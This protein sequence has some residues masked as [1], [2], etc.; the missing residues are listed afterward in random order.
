MGKHLD[1]INF[2]RRDMTDEELQKIVNEARAT[3]YE[4]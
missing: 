3:T 1:P 4:L 2:L